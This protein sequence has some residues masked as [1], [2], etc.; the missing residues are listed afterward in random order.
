[1]AAT[2]PTAAT[3]AAAAAA[4]EAEEEE[5]PHH[6][7]KEQEEVDDEAEVEDDEEEVELD[8]MLARC[9][10]NAETVSNNRRSGRH[11]TYRDATIAQAVQQQTVD[12]LM[13]ID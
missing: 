10:L 13:S 12:A 5:E 6:H 9:V 4:A 8:A 2:A 1:M 3:A 11:S 7:E